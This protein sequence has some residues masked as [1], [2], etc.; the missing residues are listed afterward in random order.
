MHR[1]IISVMIITMKTH[2]WGRRVKT[3]G[4]IF[5]AVLVLSGMVAFLR[6][7]PVGAAGS[8]TLFDTD[9]QYNVWDNGGFAAGCQVL[10]P[11]ENVE[12]TDPWTVYLCS[13]KIF[14]SGKI[15][16]KD[17]AF[18]LLRDN[19][20]RPFDPSASGPGAVPVKASG[21]TAKIPTDYVSWVNARCTQKASGPQIAGSNGTKENVLLDCT[22]QYFFGNDP[23]V[24]VQRVDPN[25]SWCVRSGVGDPKSSSFHNTVSCYASAEEACTSGNNQDLFNITTPGTA[26]TPGK[27]TNYCTNL[28]TAKSFCLEKYNYQNAIKDTTNDTMM[29]DPVLKAQFD[30]CVAGF[31][32]ASETTMCDDRAAFPTQDLVNACLAGQQGAKANENPPGTVTENPTCESNGG[33]FGWIVCPLV[34]TFAAG[35]NAVMG[36]VNGQLDFKEHLAGNTD[37]PIYKVWSAFVPIA[38]IAFAIV[39][40]IIIYST[41]IG[42]GNGKKP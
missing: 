17:Q 2:R 40:L 38:N 35:V 27:T 6:E 14:I 34:N 24:G 18:S 41:A 15:G 39:F 31:K 4:A 36:Y 42:G 29:D 37:N 12:N 26:T 30:A 13:D 21:F 11:V 10:T 25:H 32:N 7:M 23:S 28:V 22:D 3:I 8:L 16:G 19:N 5:V 20:I 9:P 33:S 1:G